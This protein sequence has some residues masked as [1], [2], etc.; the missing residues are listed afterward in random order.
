M[1]DDDAGPAAKR[2]RAEDPKAFTALTNLASSELGTT[3]LFATDEWFAEA[4]M[5]LVPD[6]PSGAGW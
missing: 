2:S 4:A 5:F 1:L 3:V 6:V